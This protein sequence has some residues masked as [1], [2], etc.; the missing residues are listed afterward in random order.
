M[1]LKPPRTYVEITDEKKLRYL[2][3]LQEDKEARR[4]LKDFIRHQEEDNQDATTKEV[5]RY[6]DDS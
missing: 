1:T 5:S 4:S 6:A 2:K 3:R